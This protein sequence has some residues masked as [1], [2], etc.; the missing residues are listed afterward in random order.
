[1]KFT[2]KM[3]SFELILLEKIIDDFINEIDARPVSK[4]VNRS[5]SKYYLEKIARE[6]IIF[7]KKRIIK[8]NANSYN[9]Y[10][11]CTLS[12]ELH[13]AALLWMFINPRMKHY[14]EF[15]EPG[16]NRIQHLNNTIH[17]KIIINL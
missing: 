10:H 5:D 8:A 12:L 4:S 13:E 11:H 7:I 9:I 6:Q 14:D 3:Q 2:Y 17:Q 15:T 16:T 1:M